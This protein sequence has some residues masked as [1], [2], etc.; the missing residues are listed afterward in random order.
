M[1][2]VGFQG[3]P[4]AYS[5]MAANKVFAE[6][7]YTLRG[8]PSFDKI[9][10][11]VE[12]KKL[13]YGVIPIENSLAG[14]IHEN[15]DHLLNHKVWISGEY[16]LRVKHSLLASPGAKMRTIKKVYSHPQALGQCAGFLKAKG[17]EPVPYFDTAG[18]ARLVAEQSD[19]TI[20]AIA[21]AHAAE[22]YELSVLRNSIEDDKKNYTRFFVVQAKPPRTKPKAKTKS[23]IVFSL[24]NVPGGLH[25][26]LSV[27]AIRDIDL[28]KIESRPLKGSP[29]KY[30]FYLDFAGSIHDEVIDRALGHLSEITTMIKVLGSYSA[31]PLQ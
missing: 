23:S 4:G 22:D 7:S 6:Q 15:Y 28:M 2:V 8:F 26:S 17:F 30:L 25:K 9:F 14:S 21:G 10:R 18:S 1:V 12:T 20:A 3:I 16:Y 31:A 13:D 5:E 24:K 11:A 29:W 19:P 27:F